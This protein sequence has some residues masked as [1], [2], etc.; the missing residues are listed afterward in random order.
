MAG[1]NNLSEK[2][3]TLL[4]Y[5]PLRHRESCNTICDIIQNPELHRDR[6]LLIK[7]LRFISY[8]TNSAQELVQANMK[9][10]TSSNQLRLSIKE[11][12]HWQLKEFS[13]VAIDKA[14]KL[15]APFIHSLLRTCINSHDHIIDNANLDLVD[16]ILLLC[17]TIVD[18]SELKE[19]N[20]SKLNKALIFVV[21]LALLC[22]GQNEHSSMFQRAI[23]Y[24][25]FSGNLSKRAV[26]SF[27]Q[28]GIIVLY[29]S[30][31]HGLHVKL[32]AVIEEI[33]EKTRFHSF[34]ISYDNIDFYDN[35]RDQ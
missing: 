28:M 10:V 15:E 26:E 8:I 24:Y 34:F 2:F 13:L 23:S 12:N 5:I 11:M 29:E 31:R 25:V 33:V 17:D 1:F 14:H 7:D 32:I 21:N 6:N 27:H 35:V 9:S 18:R 19:Q 30:I 20:L 16:D 4:C 22:Y 3:L